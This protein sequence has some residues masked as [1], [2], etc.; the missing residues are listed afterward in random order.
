VSVEEKMNA[1]GK[2][3]TASNTR[4]GREETLEVDHK[5]EGRKREKIP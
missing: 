5:E 4:L 3:N 2:L 1:T